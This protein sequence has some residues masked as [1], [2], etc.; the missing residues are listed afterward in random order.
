MNQIEL[1]SRR[2]FLANAGGGMGML[3]YA[4]LAQAESSSS[5]IQPHFTPR[6]K[7][8]IWLFMHGGPSHVDLFDP[9]P[10]LTKYSGKSLPASFGDVMTRRDV[11]KNPLLA[12]IRRFHPRGQSGLEISDFLPHIAQHADD[13]CVIRSMHGDSVNHPQSVYQMNTGSTLMGCP[14]VGSWV[15]YGL[16]SEN[17]NMPAFVVLPDPGGGLKGGP[18]AWGNGYLPASYQGVTMRPGASPIL[19]LQPQPGVSAGQQ[20]RDL[21]LIDK[22]NRRHR[23]QRDSDD[24]L[25]ARV[26][27]YELAFRMQT[28]APELVSIQNETAYTRK[29]Y[30]IDRKETREFGE[31]CLLARRMIESGVRFVQ[32]YSGD[33]NGWDAHAD[34]EKNHTEHC[35][36]TDK[37]V[38]GLLQD[39]KQRGLLDDTL[40]IW[41]GEFGRMPMSE[42]GKGRDH[43]PWG[44]SVWLAGAGIRGGRAHGAT[45]E[46]GLRAVSDKVSVNNFHATLLHLLG[47][48]HDDLTYFHNGLHKR[49][50]GP[51]E[52]E[53]IEGLIS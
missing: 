16:G 51:D 41:G 29:M 25:T 9:K 11:K 4:S 18:P 13:L 8:V 10:M 1:Q 34:V 23:E 19:D 7:R 48:D 15:A 36:R 40:V 35:Q 37:P 45:D 53:S 24:R 6:A 20:Q 38:A 22:L 32:L 44:Y 31:R 50:T 21:A 30:G 12:P 43:N 39:L 5:V 2:N 28:E 47:I 52:A 17:Q 46:F 14:S 42:Q 33:T 3:A 26:K 27:A 49:L